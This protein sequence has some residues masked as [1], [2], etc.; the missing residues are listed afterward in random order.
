M[1][2]KGLVYEDSYELP[3]FYRSCNIVGICLFISMHWLFTAHY[4]SVAFLFKLVYDDFEIDELYKRKRMLVTADIIVYCS[5]GLLLIMTACLTNIQMMVQ[6]S[7]VFFMWL[8]TGAS[9]FAMFQIAHK[10]RSLQS[11]GIFT[12]NL[13]MGSY[14]GLIFASTLCDSLA[15]V[16]ECIENGLGYG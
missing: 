15:L 12:N 6:I 8:L 1:L 7:W 11:V 4:L 3:V 16:L 9:G 5:C 13:F 2:K 14:F 10:T